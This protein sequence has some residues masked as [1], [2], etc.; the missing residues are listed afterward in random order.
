MGATEGSS[1]G[2]RGI[3]LDLQ[4][5]QSPTPHASPGPETRTDPDPQGQVSRGLGLLH[6]LRKALHSK[7]PS[8]KGNLCS[9]H[10]LVKE[11]SG[12]GL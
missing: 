8:R 5:L 4:P 2:K 1:A 9:F 11:N 6:N 12:F 3:S 7:L 10:N